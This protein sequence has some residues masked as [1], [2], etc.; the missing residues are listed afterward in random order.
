MWSSWADSRERMGGGGAPRGDTHTRETEVREMYEVS[1]LWAL[2]PPGP[3]PSALWPGP[4]GEE[5]HAKMKC[6]GH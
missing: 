3:K 5:Q 1:A 6:W 2:P 4:L